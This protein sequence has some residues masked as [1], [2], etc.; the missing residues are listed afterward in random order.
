M[1]HKT[2]EEKRT[3]FHF[4]QFTFTFCSLVRRPVGILHLRTL[5]TLCVRCRR[6][7]LCYLR[8]FLHGAYNLIK[9]LRFSFSSRFLR[10][11]FSARAGFSFASLYRNT[12]KWITYSQTDVNVCKW[13][14]TKCF[15][16]VTFL[17]RMYISLYNCFLIIYLRQEINSANF[18]SDWRLC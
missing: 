16:T 11:A 4:F 12:W 10:Y 3:L 5:E 8:G 7:E 17:Q 6:Y 15:F 9:L 13:R 2:W 18:L 1:K 14:Q